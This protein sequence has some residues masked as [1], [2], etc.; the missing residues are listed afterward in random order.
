MFQKTSIQILPMQVI[1]GHVG[2]VERYKTVDIFKIVTN[3]KKLKV[4]QSN[5]PNNGCKWHNGETLS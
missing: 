2:H 3:V 4:N 1:F 5:T